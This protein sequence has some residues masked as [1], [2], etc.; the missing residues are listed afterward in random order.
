MDIDQAREQ[1][2]EGLSYIIRTSIRQK[3]LEENAPAYTPDES[4]AYIQERVQ[5]IATL[6]RI[7]DE[8]ENLLGGV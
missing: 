2:V 8:F 1:V 4:K 5:R 7:R 6:R 3:N